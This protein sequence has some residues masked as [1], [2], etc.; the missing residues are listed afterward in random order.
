MGASSLPPRQQPR[1]RVAAL[2]P[3]RPQAR[4]VVEA[5]IGFLLCLASKW[6]T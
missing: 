2:G 6:I 1:Q 5:G 4:P 3:G